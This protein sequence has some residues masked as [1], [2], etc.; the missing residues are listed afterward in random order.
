MTDLHT[1]SDVQLCRIPDNM[2]IAQF[3]LD[4][5]HEIRPLLNND[6]PCLIDSKT[7]KK[8]DILQVSNVNIPF[9]SNLNI[10]SS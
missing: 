8:L 4:Y 2:S 3:M 1:G 7:E 5:Q 9:H 6:A 10:V